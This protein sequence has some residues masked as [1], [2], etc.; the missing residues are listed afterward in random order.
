MNA[1]M[2]YS[3]LIV[4]LVS[5]PNY[6]YIIFSFGL[7]FGLYIVFAGNEEVYGFEDCQKLHK[8]HPDFTIRNPDC[9]ALYVLCKFVL[10]NKKR[11]KKDKR[12]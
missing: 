8:Q 10:Q 7:T 3:F 6:N 11:R 9:I 2:V 4:S 12:I 1:Y 5:N